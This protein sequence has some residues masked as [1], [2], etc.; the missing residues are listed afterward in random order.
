[1]SRERPDPL[2]RPVPPDRK[3]VQKFSEDLV[4]ALRGMNGSDPLEAVLISRAVWDASDVPSHLREDAEGVILEEL[5]PW[6]E[7]VPQQ[8]KRM[9]RALA[10]GLPAPPAPPIR[11]YRDVGLGLR[12]LREILE[13]PKVLEPPQPVIP[14]LAFRGY[15]TLLASR[16]KVGKSTLAGGAAA[17]VSTGG[18]WLDSSVSKGLVLYLTLDESYRDTAR[19]LVAFGADVGR[20]VLLDRLVNPWDPVANL[21]AAAEATNPDLIVV[22]TLSEFVRDLQLKSG[23]AAAWTPVVGGI[24]RLARGRDAGLLLLHHTKKSGAEYRDS[25]AIGASVDVIMIMTEGSS[26]EVR[27]LAVRGRVPV[28]GFSARREG[29]PHDPDGGASWNLSEAMLPLEE[30]ILLQVQR[31]PG[32]STRDVRKNVGGR[33]EAIHELLGELLEQ[34]VLEDRGDQSGRALYVPEASSKHESA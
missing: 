22:D 34:G 2:E 10:L 33:T 32:S 16:E 5:E 30:R 3:A 20:V 11:P 7:R 21:E 1:M 19:R 25:S 29:D 24:S 28:E 4:E 15:S 13:D 6:L 12:T 9:S 26:P 18:P 23:N 14:R 31:H 8:V 17:A 27:K